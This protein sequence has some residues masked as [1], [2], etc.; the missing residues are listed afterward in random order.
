[1]LHRARAHLEKS[2]THV[3]FDK[4]TEITDYLTERPQSGWKTVFLEQH[5]G[6]TGD[7]P[8]SVPFHIAYSRLQIPFGVLPHPETL[9]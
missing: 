3:I 9:R 2:G 1:M 4:L 5:G 8:G 7:C 6:N